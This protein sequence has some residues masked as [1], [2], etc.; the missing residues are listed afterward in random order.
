MIAPLSFQWAR[1]R[2]THDGTGRIG[3]ARV[4][5]SDRAPFGAIGKVGIDAT[6][7]PIYREAERKNDERMTPVG[8]EGGFSGIVPEDLNFG[9]V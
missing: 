5:L 4:R 2:M 9:S 6:K 8:C 3:V 1:F 7:P